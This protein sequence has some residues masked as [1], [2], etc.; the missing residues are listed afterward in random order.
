MRILKSIFYHLSFGC[1][2]LYHKFINISSLSQVRICLQIRNGRNASTK[3][4]KNLESKKRS[5]RFANMKH[6]PAACMKR[7]RCRHEAK[8][9]HASSCAEGTLHRAK[10]CFASCC[11]TR[12]MRS[13]ARFI[14]KSTCASKCFFLAGIAGLEPAKCKSQSLVPYRLGYIPKNIA[15]NSRDAY[16]ITFFSLCQHFNRCKI[17]RTTDGARALQGCPVR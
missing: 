9:A 16:Y 4:R 15:I 13:K 14:E 10:P 6:K 1:I 12:F 7:R 11:A 8:C 3:F 5:I 2:L 17:K